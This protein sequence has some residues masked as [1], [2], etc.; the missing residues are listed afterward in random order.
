MIRNFRKTV[1]AFTLVAT[2]GGACASVTLAQPPGGPEGGPGGPGGPGRG[3]RGGP[4]GPMAK[5]V[6]PVDVPLP[7]LKKALNLNADQRARIEDIVEKFRQDRDELMPRPEPGSPRPDPAQM[8]QVM[9][10]VRALEQAANR[11]IEGVL[12]AQQK[13]MLGR[14]LKDV[15]D[16]RTVGIPMEVVEKL[17]LS[18]QQRQQIGV[19]AG[20]AQQAIKQ[21]MDQNQQNGDPRQGQRKVGDIL[22]KAHEAMLALLTD[23]QKEIL[24]QFHP[25]GP[26]H[27]GPGGP[28]GPGGPGGGP[29]RP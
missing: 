8:R 14:L 28:D 18:Q 26:P 22:H 2:F 7:A 16:F 10:Q 19:I 4:G 9:E 12:N 17:K 1:L 3:P 20:N 11:E 23:A 6:T 27:G 15:N 13:P 5:P 29:D 24:E 25:D 21:V